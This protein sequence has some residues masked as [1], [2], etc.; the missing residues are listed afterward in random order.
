MLSYFV[1]IMVQLPH[2][3]CFSSLV[4][5]VEQFPCLFENEYCVRVNTTVSW[6]P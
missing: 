3:T 4:P 6:H 2:L 5:E 1:V